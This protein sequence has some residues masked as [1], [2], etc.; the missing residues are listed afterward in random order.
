MPS[1]SPVSAESPISPAPLAISDMVPVFSAPGIIHTPL[2]IPALPSAI[3]ALP[4]ITAPPVSPLGALGA[5]PT[6]ILY[7]ILSWSSDQPSETKNSLYALTRV[8]KAM[9]VLAL[10]QYIRANEGILPKIGQFHIYMGKDAFYIFPAW[11]R[12]DSFDSREDLICDFTLPDIARK[13]EAVDIG[14]NSLGPALRPRSLTLS[15]DLNFTQGVALL[16]VAGRT[17]A[18][19]IDLEIFYLDFSDC[20]AIKKCK[21]HKLTQAVELRIDWPSLSSKQWRSLLRAISAPK[22]QELTLGG[23]V[24]WTALASF[25]SRHPTITKLRLPAVNRVTQKHS[26]FK[27]PELFSLQGNM[28]LVIPFIKLLSRSPNLSIEGNMPSD[29]SLVDTVHN[30]V[31][32]LVACESDVSLVSNLTS[33]KVNG[34]LTKSRSF[35]ISTLKKW[36]QFPDR[37]ARLIRLRLNIAG[38]EDSVLLVSVSFVLNSN[39]PKT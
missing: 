32:S 16:D 14:L 6:E 1:G 26:A 12:S 2:I 17:R 33:T 8:S 7:E 24:P 23:N 11:V 13:I 39:M 10:P 28:T 27:L 20:E 4:I 15:G 22:L 38:I 19:S 34:K 35:S 37:L 9:A 5:V 36:R 29:L 21:V 31:A 3:P 25:L 30:I 18:S